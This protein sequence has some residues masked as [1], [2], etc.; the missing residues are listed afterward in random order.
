MLI[1]LTNPVHLDVGWT[2]YILLLKGRI[3]ASTRSGQKLEYIGRT[4][5]TP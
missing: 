2:W 5:E 3:Y 4:L 1:K